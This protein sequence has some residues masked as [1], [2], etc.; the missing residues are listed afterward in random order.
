MTEMQ[1]RNNSDKEAFSG[2]T[3]VATFAES[4]TMPVVFADLHTIE[5]DNAD[6]DE[7]DLHCACTEH[8]GAGCWVPSTQLCPCPQ[9]RPI[10]FCRLESYSLWVSRGRSMGS[11]E[12]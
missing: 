1:I 8:K 3:G 9:R 2:D 5:S 4:R 7:L 6:R 11:Y 12:W 10:R